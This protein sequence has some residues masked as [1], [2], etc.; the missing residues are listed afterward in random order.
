M[1]SL[2]PWFATSCTVRCSPAVEK[3][4]RTPRSSSAV[5]TSLPANICCR[6]CVDPSSARSAC[7]PCSTQRREHD[8]SR[9][10]VCASRHLP[11][12]PGMIALVLSHRPVGQRV[13]RMLAREGVDARRLAQKTH[14]EAV[15]PDR[16]GPSRSLDQPAFHRRH[17]SGVAARWR[18]VGDLRRGAGCRFSIR[19]PA[20]P[21]VAASCSRL[22]C[23]AACVVW[24]ASTPPIRPA[25]G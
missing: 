3:N 8:R 16:G 12:G 9:G 24:Q 10:V 15:S 11:L 21:A 14:A 13:V 7:R 2:P 1:G 17:Q 6:P 23:R 5:P 25:K 20:R 4:S 22:E 18:A 19:Q